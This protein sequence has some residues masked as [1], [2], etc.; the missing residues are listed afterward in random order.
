[1]SRRRALLAANRQA[2]HLRRVPAVLQIALDVARALVYLHSRRII[3]LDIKSAN[4]LLTRRVAGC[5]ALRSM[6]A[7]QRVGSWL[8]A[9]PRCGAPCR[10]GTAKVGDVGM[11][12]IM[13]GDYVSG[14]LGTLAWCVPAVWLKA[15]PL[16]RRTSIGAQ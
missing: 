12:K 11:A 13:A 8:T 3:H 2:P 14:V 7:R 15:L 10:D 1:M 16:T 6:W 5:G 9:A 4:V